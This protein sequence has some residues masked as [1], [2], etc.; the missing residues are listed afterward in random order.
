M[1]DQGYIDARTDAAGVTIE[2]SVCVIGAG[3]AGLT[4]VR[5]L[6]DTIPDVVLIE[7][8]GLD[9]DGETQE[10]YSAQML[11]LSYYD[12]AASRLRYFGGT[13]N[14]WS[15]FCRANDIIDYE[16]RPALGLPGW[17][18]THADLQPFVAAAADELGINSNFLDPAALLSA[19]G[20][21]PRGL[22][23]RLSTKLESKIFQIASEKEIRLG[24]KYKDA[25][26]ASQNVRVYL[27]LN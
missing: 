8:G 24:P 2:G 20:I 26:G 1:A 22:A 13:S 11:G 18:I 16:P 9:L 17:P 21:D 10:L 5:S 4:L 23:E 6:V 14:H 12:L 19:A 25:I 7:S 15:G 27:H 3:A